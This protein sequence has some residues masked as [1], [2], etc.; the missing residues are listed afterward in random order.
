MIELNVSRAFAGGRWSD[1]SPKVS[2]C[3]AAFVSSDMLVAILA[4]VTLAEAAA[5]YPQ[6]QQAVR[7]ALIQL[8]RPLDAYLLLVVPE[9]SAEAYPHARRAL[10]DPLI[11]RKAV[12]ELGNDDP[13]S[14]LLRQFPLLSDSRNESL[15][16]A[17]QEALPEPGLDE[18]AL[19]DGNSAEGI[20]DDLLEKVRKLEG[21]SPL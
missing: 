10:D 14:A 7:E 4:T 15:Q 2:G 11:C 19:L 3:T 21:H 18:L 12:I 8:Q 9:I 20:V 13:S 16:P 1:I 5:E 17:H 6:V